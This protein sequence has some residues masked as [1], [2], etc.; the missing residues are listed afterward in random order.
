MDKLKVNKRE[1]K[2]YSKLMLISELAPL[3]ERIKMLEQSKRCTFEKFEER[4]KSK[5]EEFTDWDD[6]IEWKAYQ[7]KLEE[8]QNRIK[9]IEKVNHVEITE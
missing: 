4:I 6:Y 1:I 8:L 5:S 3:R 7:T 2:E 9:E